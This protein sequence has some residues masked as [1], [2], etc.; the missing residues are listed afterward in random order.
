MNENRFIQ[1]LACF[2]IVPVELRADIDDIYLILKWDNDK[3]FRPEVHI[4]REAIKTFLALQ[5]VIGEF[6]AN[7]RANRELLKKEGI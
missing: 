5:D 7:I 6:F 4:S 1:K 3:L 2:G